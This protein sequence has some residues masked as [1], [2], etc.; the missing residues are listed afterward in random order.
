VFTTLHS[1]HL[2]PFRR[3]GRLKLMALGALVVWVALALHPVDRLAWLL[4]NLLVFAC[5][6]VLVL[7]HRRHPLSDL[8]Y[9]LIWAFFLLHAFGTHFTYA[10]VPLGP[11]ARILGF[12]RN[13]YDRIVHFTF[14]LLLAYPIREWLSRSLKLRGPA[15]YVLA[16]ALVLAFSTLYE[17]ME[18]L[19]VV[20]LPRHQPAAAAFLGLQED[21]WDSQ[22]DVS[23]ALLGAG[24]TSVL[25]LLLEGRVRARGR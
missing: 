15:A 1:H 6:P 13:P 16:L 11:L 21:F 23:M 24:L 17:L 14:G 10:Q 5:L 12:Q 20:V 25:A 18:W 19:V 7:L 2:V 8:S 3:N 22:K 4:E 9:L